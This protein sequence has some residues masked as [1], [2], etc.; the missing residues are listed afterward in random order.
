MRKSPGIRRTLAAV[1][2]NAPLERS[3]QRMK[4]LAGVEMT[5]KEVERTAEPVART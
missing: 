5:A 4:L 2:H 1:G 3:C